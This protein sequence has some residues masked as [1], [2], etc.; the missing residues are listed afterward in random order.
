M[1]ELHKH[2][3]W[4]VAHPSRTFGHHPNTQ[5]TTRC[6]QRS[7]GARLQACPPGK[8]KEVG[9]G[10]GLTGKP[11]CTQ[12]VGFPQGKKISVHANLGSARAPGLQWP[13]GTNLLWRDPL[14][15]VRGHNGDIGPR[16]G[17]HQVAVPGAKRQTQATNTGGQGGGWATHHG[18][19]GPEVLG[20]Q[21]TQWECDWSS[22]EDHKPDP[23]QGHHGVGVLLH[24]VH[25]HGAAG[26]SGCVQGTPNK[27]SSPCT[28]LPTVT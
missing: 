23:P 21:A 6:L 11:C 17:P 5:E 24:S 15:H 13:L 18:V 10:G 7:P 1:K 19:R 9:E 4:A 2:R 14:P 25:P 28:Y 8:H 12:G 16:H 20:H 3:S 22:G 26:A 27:R